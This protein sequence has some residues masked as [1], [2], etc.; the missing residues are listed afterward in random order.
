M[1]ANKQTNIPLVT[2]TYDLIL[3]I[4]PKL[5]KFPKDQR[6]LLAERIENLLLDILEFLIEAVYSKDKL[7]ILRKINLKLEK[8]RFLIRISKD[9]RF[10]NINS[11]EFSS[12]S[13]NE[14]GKMVGGW[15]RAANS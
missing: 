8:L 12:R 1:T 6:Y 13:I 7:Y 5:G 9:M 15:I 2:K 3:W 14:I 4:L 11:Y 10:I